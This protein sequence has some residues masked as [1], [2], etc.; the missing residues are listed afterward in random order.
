MNTGQ[1]QN[2]P[3]PSG[4]EERVTAYGRPYYVCHHIRIT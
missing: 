3:L 1:N 4:W 2:H